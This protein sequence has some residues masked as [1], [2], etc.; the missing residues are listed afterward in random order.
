[1]R[2]SQ[3]FALRIGAV[4]VAAAAI[5]VPASGAFAG[6]ASPTITVTPSTGLHDG[7]T[8][9]V[10][11]SNFPD[12]TGHPFAIVQCSSLQPDGSGCNT[13]PSA[14]GTTDGA[15][16]IPATP[17]VVHTGTV[18]AGTCKPGSTCFLVASSD[19]ADPTDLAAVA[20]HT[21]KFAPFPSITVKPSKGIHSGDTVKV[22]GQ[23]FPANKPLALST[24]T[25][26]SGD[27]SKCDS[28]DA[29]LG[30]AVTD[31]SGS[32]KNAKLK[33]YAKGDKGGLCKVGGKCFVGATTDISDNPPGAD[34]SQDAAARIHLVG[35]AI[36]TK[37]KAAFVS[38]TSKIVGKVKAHNKGVAGLKEV[39][40]RRKGGHWTKVDSFK[41]HKGGKF[42]S[43][44]LTKSGKY[45][46]KTPKQT[47]GSK[48]YGSS[49]SKA[50]HV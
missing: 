43:S 27:I 44:K 50:I 17:V 11:G 7:D 15:G 45:R 48:S 23:D 33:V 4:G 32:F 47:K 18:G 37:T 25:S 3:K 9:T 14:S 46:V 36:A 30:D 29:S 12:H 35:N 24:C 49:H 13:T 31:G 2:F 6:T 10:T 39:L 5:V 26:K 20:T 42:H 34:K 19:P 38:K 41:S 16:N 1:M 28:T 40:D 8:V 22:S 21:I